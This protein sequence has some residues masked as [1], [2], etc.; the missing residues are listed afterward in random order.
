[1]KSA[2]ELTADEQSAILAERYTLRAE[3]YDAFWSPVIRPV[4]E[5]LLAHLLLSQATNIIDVGT[6]AGALL[7]LIQKAAPKAT[8]LGVDR[9]EGM[10]RLAKQKH[11][12]P[13]ALTDVQKLELPGGQFDAAVV[14]FVLFHLP[15]PERCLQEVHRVLSPGGSIGTVTWATEL[16]PRANTVWDEELAAAGARLVELPAT[17]N[18]ARCDS[19]AKMSSLLEL[20]GFTRK[21]IWTESLEH[22]W[23]PEDHFEYHIRSTSLIRL[24]SL[25]SEDRAACIQRVRHRLSRLGQDQ[26]VFRG[27]VILATAVKQ[28]VGG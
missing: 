3:A 13:L 18:R 12:G 2:G 24:Q 19:P 17:D 5:R 1:M 21:E 28:R 14:A 25:S 23:Q 6:G 15:S 27:D 7:P 4:G 11:P 10:L 16:P 9:S 26:Y 22:R 20:A 8:V